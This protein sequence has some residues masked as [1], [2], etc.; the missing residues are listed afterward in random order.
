MLTTIQTVQ[1]FNGSTTFYWL[2]VDNE[3]GSSADGVD[4]LDSYKSKE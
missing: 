3:Q 1:S 2:L 4:H